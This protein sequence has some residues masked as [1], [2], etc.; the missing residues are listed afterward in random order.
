MYLGFDEHKVK[1]KWVISISLLITSL[2]FFLINEIYTGFIFFGAGLI[3]FFKVGELFLEIVDVIIKLFYNIIKGN[4]DEVKDDIITYV[5]S[6]VIVILPI[7]LL[8]N[9]LSD[10]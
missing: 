1:I 10:N 4:W 9:Y 5:I 7:I 6:F 3:W 8:Y 2:V